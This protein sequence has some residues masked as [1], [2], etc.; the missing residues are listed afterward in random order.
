MI[1]T[2]NDNLRVMTNQPFIPNLGL[3]FHQTHMIPN[4]TMRRA[5]G[6]RAMPVL[7][8]AWAATKPVKYLG[9]VRGEEGKRGRGER[10]EGYGNIVAPIFPP[11]KSMPNA[12]AV[13][14][15]ESGNNTAMVNMNG[16]IFSDV[17]SI[18]CFLILFFALSSYSFS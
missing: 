9:E 10:G 17:K 16:N 13:D 15:V 14:P 6:A 11:K 18:S 7:T 8:E 3:T 2:K 4:P 5:M 12:I 1:V